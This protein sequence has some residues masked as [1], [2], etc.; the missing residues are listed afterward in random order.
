VSP[1]TTL[2]SMFQRV[3]VLENRAQILE[4]ALEMERDR[5]DWARQRLGA[6]RPEPVIDKPLL[7][8]PRARQ[9]AVKYARSFSIESDERA[10]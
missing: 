1:D 9:H 10:K 4:S 5:I 2:A 7:T 8:C 6:Y 3:E